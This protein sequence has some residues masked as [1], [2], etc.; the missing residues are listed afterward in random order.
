MKKN[1]WIFGGIAGF[2]VAAFMVISSALCY[3]SNTFESSML[4][5][6]A[7]MLLAFSFVFVG[8]KNYRDKYNNGMVSFVQALKIGGLIMLIASSVYVVVWL[9]DFYLFI[10]DFMDKYIAHTITQAKANGATQ[11]ELSKQIAELV[12]YKEKY[13]N[14]IWVILLTYAEVLPV[15]IVVTLISALILKRN[16]PKTNAVIA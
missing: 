15:G 7:G 12:P 5:G 11:A 10:P 9:F 6:Y 14:P 3:H 4:L 1:I 2:I 13:K 16:T 8:I